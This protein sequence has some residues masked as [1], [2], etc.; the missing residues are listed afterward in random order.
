MPAYVSQFES[1]DLIAGIID[2]T[3]SAEDDPHWARSGARDPQEYAFWAWRSCGVACLRSLLIERTGHSPAPVVLARELLAA[4]GYVPHAGGL[5]GLVYRPFVNYLRTRWDIAAE[6]R[7]DYTV[8]AL[9]DDL[10]RGAWV[11]AS[12]HSTIRNAPAPP[13]ERGGHLVLAY[14]ATD[15][16]LEFHDPGAPT[17]RTREAVRLPIDVFDGYFA[18]RG[19]VVPPAASSPGAKNRPGAS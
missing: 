12:V 8:T 13:P 10:R 7:T 4:G 19:V 18:R 9:A 2:G 16:H 5:R 11:I 6:V 17:A 14:A 3:V 1:P 15:T